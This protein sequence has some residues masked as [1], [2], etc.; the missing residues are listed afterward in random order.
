[1]RPLRVV[2]S[3]TPPIA[4]SPVRSLADT[5]LRHRLETLPARHGGVVVLA[6]LAAV[7]ALGF[8]LRLQAALT[9]IA[10]P[11]ADALVYEELAISLSE[12]RGYESGSARQA[13][14]WSPGAP[15]LY[16]AVFELTGGAGRERALVVVALIG[17]AL[18]LLTYLL[19]RRLAGERRAVAG[20]AAAAVAAVY[21]TFI[22][23]NGRMLSEPLAGMLLA[24]ALLACLRALER[25]GAR[26]WVVPGVLLGLLVLTRPEYLPVAAALA[27]A[28]L[29]LVGRRAGRGAGLRSAALFTAACAAVLVPWTVRNYVVL[30]RV[31]P[32][33]TGGG[34][35]LFIGTYLP[36]QGENT[37]TKLEL[38][39]RFGAPPGTSAD[40]LL[41]RVAAARPELERDQALSAIGK[42]NL[43][44]Y[45]RDQ[46]LDYAEM[47]TRKTAAI[48]RRGSSPSMAGTAAVALHRGIVL[49]ALAGLVALAVR[50]REELVL[51]LVPL[52]L[53]TAVGAFLLAV[54][55]R[56]VPLMPLVLALAAS[57]AVWLSVALARRVRDRS[58]PGA[59]R[60]A[61][62]AGAG[63][64]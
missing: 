5:P 36:G 32:V 28:V 30:D 13:S 34:K 31:V 42:E 41:D 21:P 23:H 39:R 63:R 51:V 1:V 12:G 61:D 57:G 45:L 58:V 16:A 47:L 50:R 22:D 10:D 18:I 25:T 53:I 4:C 62:P 52:T 40:V 64:A 46:P 20:L 49:L 17:T 11:G 43:R 2:P 33:S 56:A 48:W 29:V 55:R 19:A 26:A 3:S 24:G 8:G 14:D 44:R 7:L 59:G 38:T 15:L 54:P 27:L 9:P 6:V 35:A 60:S 37:A